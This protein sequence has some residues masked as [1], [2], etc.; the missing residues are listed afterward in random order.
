MQA[1]PRMCAVLGVPKSVSVARLVGMP[2][3]LS[4][5]RHAMS[6]ASCMNASGPFSPGSSLVTRPFAKPVMGL[7]PR[8]SFSEP[9]SVR[10]YSMM[11]LCEAMSL[12]RFMAR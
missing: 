8:R 11:V 6:V 7:R 10:M 1:P 3:T 9:S 4:A 5:K 12:A 2:R